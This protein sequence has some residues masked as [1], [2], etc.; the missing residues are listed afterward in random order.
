MVGIASRIKDIDVA[1][2]RGVPPTS[3]AAQKAFKTIFVTRV[4]QFVPRA[5]RIFH[6]GGR[7]GARQ[8]TYSEH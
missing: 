2:A 4:G 1:C 7:C 6:I 8:R 3:C 5:R